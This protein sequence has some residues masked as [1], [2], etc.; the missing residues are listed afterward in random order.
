MSRLI[1]KKWR[2]LEDIEARELKF[3]MGPCNTYTHAVQK[4]RLNLRTFWKI[5]V[6]M[7][8]QGRYLESLRHTRHIS[9]QFE[10]G[11]D[12]LSLIL[13]NE[14]AESNVTSNKMLSC[15]N[16]I[17]NLQ[18]V[19]LQIGMNCALLVDSL[20]PSL[21]ICKR[22]SLLGIILFRILTKIPLGYMHCTS[23]STFD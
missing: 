22:C 15:I 9:C 1:H 2:P 18:A 16:N 19:R 23:V 20:D 13:T 11:L 5:Q 21:I 4:E 14:M 8:W 7:V 10:I 6:E 12:S 17:S 3:Y